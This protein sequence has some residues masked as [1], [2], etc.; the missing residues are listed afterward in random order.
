[1]SSQGAPDSTDCL[2]APTKGPQGAG[3]D[4]LLGSCLGS[5]RLT[6]KLDQGGMGTVYLGEHVD[7]GSRVAI[8]VLHPG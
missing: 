5:F 4:P 3:T 7:I 6:R 1:M 8:K 2:A